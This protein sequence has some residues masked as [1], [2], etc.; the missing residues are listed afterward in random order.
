MGYVN[1]VVC[2]CLVSWVFKCILDVSPPSN[3]VLRKIFLYFVSFH[4]V[5]LT[6]SFALCL[7]LC[8]GDKYGSIFILLHTDSPYFKLYYRAI[9]KKE[10]HDVDIKRDVLISGIKSKTQTQIH[11]S[12]ETWFLIKKSEIH[13]GK[14][15]TFSINGTDLTGY[16]CVE[17]WKQIHIY[18]LAQNS[19]SSGSKTSTYNPMEKK[20]GNNFGCVATGDDFLDRKN[21]N[22]IGT[23]INN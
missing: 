8:Q 10:L 20:V 7:V 13:K 17:G 12:M 19:S 14:K 22:S 3:V 15:G 5:L 21:T 2:C 6:V 4:F 1:R 23:K 18:H 16:L 9:V 11:T